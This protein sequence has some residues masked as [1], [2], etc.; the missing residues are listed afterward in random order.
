[1]AG[2]LAALAAAGVAAAEIGE[3]LAGPPRLEVV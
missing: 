3:V 2:L 1:V